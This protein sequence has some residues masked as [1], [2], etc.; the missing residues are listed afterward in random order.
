MSRHLA[1]HRAQSD[2]GRLKHFYRIEK[3]GDADGVHPSSR[4]LHK[5]PLGREGP[6]RVE[7]FVRIERG[8]T[9]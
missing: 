2:G 8:F 5:R 9:A 6:S 3:T 7:N 4:A 1:D